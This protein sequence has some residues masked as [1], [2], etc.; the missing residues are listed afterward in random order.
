MNGFGNFNF[1]EKKH[2]VCLKDNCRADFPPPEVPHRNLL[3]QI[4]TTILQYFT[5]ATEKYTK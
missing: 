4:F 2:L 5:S 3:W 1:A